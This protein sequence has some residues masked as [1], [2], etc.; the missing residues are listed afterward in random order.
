MGSVEQADAAIEAYSPEANWGE[1][2]EAGGDEHFCQ[3]VAI[4]GLRPTQAISIARPGMTSKSAHETA[5]ATMTRPEIKA[6]I[7]RLQAGQ[8]QARAE[9]VLLTKAYLEET[10]RVVIDDNIDDKKG[11]GNVIKAVHAAM[12]LMGYDRQAPE[13][14][15][16]T[17]KNLDDLKIALEEKIR[18]IQLL[19]APEPE[20]IDVG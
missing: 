13:K 2:L 8:A 10:L 7:R 4:E 19:Q 11:H 18:D 17:P 20:T 14:Q 9:S 5:S 15:V 12:K 1:P 16:A 6:R 3:M